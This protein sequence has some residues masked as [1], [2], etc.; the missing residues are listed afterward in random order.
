MLH[1]NEEVPDKLCTLKMREKKN[2]QQI[3]A[4]YSKTTF[5]GFPKP[6]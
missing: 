2:I 5:K 1:N 6:R 4:M 3:G